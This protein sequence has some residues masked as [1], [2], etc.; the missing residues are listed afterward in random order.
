MKIKYLGTAAYEGIPGLFCQC[1]ICKNA[2]KNGGKEVRTRA[3]ALINDDLLID[4]GPDTHKHYL[5]YKFDWLK[6]KYCLITHSH[7]DHFYIDDMEQSQT[8]YVHGYPLKLEYYSD[9]AAYDIMNERFLDPK[10]CQVAHANKVKMGQI[11][12]IGNYQ[13]MAVRANHSLKTSPVVYAIGDGKKSILYLHDTGVLSDESLRQLQLF[14][15]FDL[16]SF[17]CTGG[18][19]KGWYDG[20][21]CLESNLLLIDKMEKMGLINDETIKVINHF[22]HNGQASYHDLLLEAQKYH[23]IVS[24]DGLEI[25]I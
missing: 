1:D 18:L 21:M 23:I 25:N 12:N 20:H 16:V 5:T 13:V 6:I 2:I 17:D 14:K 22:S 15:T 24:Y 19:Q 8:G 4:F 11:M 7:S 9:E 3:Q 10:M